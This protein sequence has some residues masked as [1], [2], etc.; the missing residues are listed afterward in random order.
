MAYRTPYSRVEGLG[1]AHAGVEHFWRQRVTAVAL[2]FLTVWFAVAMLELAGAPRAAIIGY[3]NQPLH[4]VMM[5]LFVIAAAIHMS[6]GVQ[7]VIEDYIQRES[8]KIMLL[9]L[10]QAFAWG[11]AAASLFAMFH[12]AV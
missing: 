3:L 8:T 11:V 2:I 4:A 9:L 5:V 1:S 10:N 12:I 6:L 7:V